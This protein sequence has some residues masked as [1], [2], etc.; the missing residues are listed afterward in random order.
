MS[1]RR[2]CFLA[3]LATL[4][5][6][7][8]VGSVSRPTLKGEARRTSLRPIQS[9]DTRSLGVGKLLVASRDLGDPNFAK[10]VILLVHYDTQGVVGLVLNRRTDFPLSQALR[11]LKAA[12]DR[13]DPVYLGGPVDTPMV[14]ALYQSPAKVEGAEDVFGKVYLIS[15]KPVLEQTILTRPDPQIFHVYLGYAGWN[16]DQ[17]QREVAV[18]SWFIFPADASTVFSS[19][20]DSLWLQMIRKTDL[21]FADSRPV[22]LTQRGGQR[23]RSAASSSTFTFRKN[24]AAASGSTVLMNIPEPNSNPAT[25]VSRG[26]MLTYQW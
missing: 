26:M 10:T 4:V 8:A 13:S 16:M 12:K 1:L 19:D 14:F 22:N 21:E 17:L 11:D 3:S 23:R 9:K 25:R 24:S 15:A 7:A 18:G 6:F 20:P 5:A 2:L